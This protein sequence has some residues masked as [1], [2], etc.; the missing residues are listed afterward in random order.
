ML[1]AEI[2]FLPDRLN[3]RSVL[4]TAG[5]AFYRLRLR[6]GPRGHDVVNPTNR[7]AS[8]SFNSIPKRFGRGQALAWVG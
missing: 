7:K 5:D 3:C 4:T 2:P 1:S 6:S 8:E